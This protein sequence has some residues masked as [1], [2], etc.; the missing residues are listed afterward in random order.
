[1]TKDLGTIEMRALIQG[2]FAIEILGGCLVKGGLIAPSTGSVDS[3]RAFQ[4]KKPVKGFLEEE[5]ED[6][7]LAFAVERGTHQHQ[8]K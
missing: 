4:P 2:H 1:M 8:L 7:R 5:G 6:Q 3:R